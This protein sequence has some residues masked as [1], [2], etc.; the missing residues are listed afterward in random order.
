V[1]DDVWNEISDETVD[2]LFSLA[3]RVVVLVSFA[4]DHP[5]KHV[6]EDRLDLLV[7]ARGGIRLGVNAGELSS[8]AKPSI[9]VKRR[10]VNLMTLSDFRT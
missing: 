9:P 4:C 7:P 3:A 5:I 6:P 1:S 10:T 2:R 8:S